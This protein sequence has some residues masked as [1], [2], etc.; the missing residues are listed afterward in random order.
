[1]PIYNDA[2]N[3]QNCNKV[4]TQKETARIKDEKTLR[5]CEPCWNDA[6]ILLAKVTPLWNL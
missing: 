3:C 1:M 5:F 2:K 4:L 6:K